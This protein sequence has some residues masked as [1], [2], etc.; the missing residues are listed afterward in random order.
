MLRCC[1]AETLRGDSPG[2]KTDLGVNCDLARRVEVT[3]GEN[4]RRL[5]QCVRAVTDK[6][7]VKIFREGVLGL[8]M[9]SHTVD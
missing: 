7:S 2:Q 5:A 6:V 9:F 8:S 3:E 1:T 4:E